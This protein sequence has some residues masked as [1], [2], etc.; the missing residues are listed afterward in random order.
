MNFFIWPISHN[1]NWISSHITRRPDIRPVIRFNPDWCLFTSRLKFFSS[2]IR[3]YV[4]NFWYC[5]TW[6]QLLSFEIL[7]RIK[8]YG[9]N[10]YWYPRTVYSE[11]IILCLK[12]IPSVI[13]F[14]SSF[15]YRKFSILYKVLYYMKILL[16]I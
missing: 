12:I 11:S 8:A 10:A 3:E 14:R 2:D 15:S 9:Q 7:N 6:D 13:F 16:V 4:W 5:Y 1:W